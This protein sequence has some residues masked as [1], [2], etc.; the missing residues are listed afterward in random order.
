MEAGRHDAIALAH[1]TE[2]ARLCDMRSPADSMAAAT[3]ELDDYSGCGGRPRGLCGGQGR[4]V[5]IWE[6]EVN[7]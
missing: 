6:A 7:N 2:E 4:V 5:T 3:D 1:V